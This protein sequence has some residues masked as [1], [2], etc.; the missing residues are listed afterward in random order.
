MLYL[1]KVWAPSLQY[2][3]THHEVCKSPNEL[4]KKHINKLNTQ[5]LNSSQF[6]RF[7][8]Q[9][10]DS[11]PHV[12]RV[13]RVERVERPS[14]PLPGTSKSEFKGR[15]RADTCARHGPRMRTAP[16]T[17]RTTGRGE[18]HAPDAEGSESEE[19]NG[20]HKWRKRLRGLFLSP[21][22]VFPLFDQ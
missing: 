12:E 1:R 15:C 2:H 9:M 18:T 3:H 8:A 5:C 22:R 14:D 4:N 10:P 11:L 21:F 20:R 19:S 6:P 16:T 13:Q 17:A 7:V